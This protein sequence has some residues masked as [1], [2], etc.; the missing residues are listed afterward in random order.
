MATWRTLIGL[1]AAL[2]VTAT[3]RAQT[4]PL[5][6]LPT[7][8]TCFHQQLD[9]RLT[10]T[11]KMKQEGKDL[12]L[13]QT[14]EAVHD[15]TERVLVV[16]ADAAQ[17][18]ARHY[19]TA[20]VGITTN[21]QRT[22]NTLRPDRAALV[23]AHRQRDQVF[24][25]CPR[26]TLPLTR[27]EVHVT[28]HFDTLSVPGLLP[29]RA[30]AVGDTWKLGNATVQALC[31]FEGLASH[32]LTGKLE[33]V[34]GTV[35]HLSVRGNAA[36]VD[37]GATV[38]VE[39]NASLEFDLAAKRLTRVVWNQTDTREQGPVSPAGKAQLTVTLTRTPIATPPELNDYA[40]NAALAH[41][42][43]PEEMKLLSYADPKGRY[44]VLHT[45][46]W[47]LVARTE[48]HLVLRLMDRGEFVAQA[49][50]TPW[51]QTAPGE[52]LSGTKFQEIVQ[53]TPGW[54]T[55]A[56]LEGDTKELKDLPAGYWG[57]RVAA[58]GQLDGVD[59]MQYFCLLAGPQGEQLVL[60]FTMKPGD[61]HKLDT[62]DLNLLRGITFPG[63]RPDG[64]EVKKQ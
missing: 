28:E 3:A 24:A 45:R 57:Y 18:S 33:K 50:L 59:V 58:E 52:H 55:K 19:K 8:D 23:V 42:T 60:A 39:V 35:A 44:A 6:E 16:E 32:S 53:N 30:A 48:E 29:Q 21:G 9:M 27:D 12:E 10:G 43:P 31:N 46:D 17:R 1:V 14:A 54:V 51:K 2:G 4:Y 47:Q 7:Q 15:Y 56:V 49:T 34:Q 37:L 41:R 62:R 22:E 63:G 38:Q 11:L 36:G 26:E 64:A 40:L 25:Y 20:R 13:K 5:T 61:T